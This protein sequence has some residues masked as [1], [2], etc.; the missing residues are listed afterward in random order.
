MVPDSRVHPR[1][2]RSGERHP[3]YLRFARDRGFRLCTGCAVDELLVEGGRV[4]GVRV[5]ARTIRADAVIDATGAWAGRL[6]PAS[7]PLPLQPFRRHLFVSGPLANPW[8]REA[9]FVWV[10]RDELYARRE[11]DA[12]LLSPC[13]ETAHPPGCPP[14]DPTAAELLAVTLARHAP[15]LGHLTLRR[16]WACLRTFA[17]D[18]R[19]VV[20]PDP[21]LT[22]LY[23]VAALGGFGVTTSAA[24]AEVAVLAMAGKPADWLDLAEVS[25]AR[26]C[27]AGEMPAAKAAHRQ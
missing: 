21:T 11:G 13:D 15:G 17:P 7:V 2:G 19:P 6:R 20:G 4:T 22:G 1:R 26:L 16:S 25:P 23:H 9:P 27:G 8:P 14:A 10:W 24:I 5:G 12:L 3:P 18:R